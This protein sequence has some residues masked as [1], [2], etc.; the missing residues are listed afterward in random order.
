MPR[1]TIL[2]IFTVMTILL[3]EPLLLAVVPFLGTAAPE[4][5]LLGVI[6][7]AHGVKGSPSRG[8]FASL[9]TGY[10]MDL[11]TGAPVGMFCFTYVAMYFSIRLISF[12]I[13][14]RS[15][16]TQSLMGGI[17]SAITGL[18]L[19]SIDKWLNP[20]PHTWALLN[21]IPRQSF[22]TALFS[23]VYFYVLW[24]IDRRLTYEAPHEGVFR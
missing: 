20:L 1:T 14:G 10:L 2:F 8:A 17:F 12:K 11:L 19:V 18:F 22:V 13:Y 9:G 24:L 4:F 5:G 21:Q 23:P 7:F 6:Y 16:I 3:V 15:I